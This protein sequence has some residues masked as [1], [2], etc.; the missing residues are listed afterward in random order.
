MVALA[1]AASRRWRAS[2]SHRAAVCSTRGAELRLVG[3][4]QQD[5]VVELARH[6]ERPP[7]RARR[8]DAVE[9]RAAP[10]VGPAH[11]QRRGAARAVECRHRPSDSDSRSRRSRARAAAAR[12]P[13]APR[14]RSLAPR[15]RALAPRSRRNA[16]GGAVQSTRPH[17]LARS[18]RTPSAAVQKRSARSRRTLRLSMSAGEAA[19]AGQHAEQRHLGQAHGARAVVDHARSRRRRAPARSRR[20]RR[21]R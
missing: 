18:A 8:E 2:P 12:R 11:G 9:R 14:G 3:A 19:G 17:S 1:P 15:A 13:L 7:L 4:Q 10:R 16:A 5:G 6:G 20:R 21:R